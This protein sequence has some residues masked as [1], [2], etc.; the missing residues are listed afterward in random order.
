MPLI[1]IP[2]SKLGL[3]G[4]FLT[5]AGVWKSHFSRHDPA[6]GH[7]I[8]GLMQERRNSI[9]NALE[10]RLSYTNPSI[11]AFCLALATP[12]FRHESGKWWL[13]HENT[14]QITSVVIIAYDITYLYHSQNKLPGH[15]ISLSFVFPRCSNV[16]STSKKYA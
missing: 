6:Q 1:P 10:L 5:T 9:A 8:D 13:V 7:H 3:T 4:I 16:L 15:D 11:C 14:W 2:D 12:S